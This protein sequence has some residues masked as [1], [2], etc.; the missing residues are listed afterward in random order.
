M[1]LGWQAGKEPGRET[2]KS[3]AKRRIVCVAS[4]KPNFL[5]KFPGGNAEWDYIH[6]RDLSGKN[7]GC[8]NKNFISDLWMSNLL[9]VSMAEAR[10]QGMMKGG[11][12]TD[13]TS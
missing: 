11:K 8:S 9:Q 7:A 4:W 5:Y 12:G 2:K 1:L 3:L 10:E 13:S 6:Q